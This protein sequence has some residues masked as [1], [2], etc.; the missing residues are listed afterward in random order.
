MGDELEP[1]FVLPAAVP[2]QAESRASKAR[3]DALLEARRAQPAAVE[4]EAAS[5]EPVA[6]EAM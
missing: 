6:W 4:W 5:N 2:G 1:G 3:L